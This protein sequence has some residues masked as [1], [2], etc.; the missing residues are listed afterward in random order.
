MRDTYDRQAGVFDAQRS[1]ALVEAGW[2]AR[3]ADAL[4]GSGR[5]LDLG[6]GTGRPIAGWLTR[7]G[8]RVTGI[9]IAPAMIEIAR[10]HCPEGDWRIADMR[11]LDLPE[12]FD[13]LVGWDSFFHLSPDAQR[14]VLPRLAGHLRPGGALMLTVGPRAGEVR[15]RVGDAPVY[16]ASLSPAEYAT[17][18]EAT[19]MRLAGFHAEDPDC[20]GRSVLLARKD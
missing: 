10:R 6:C 8:F 2:L 20:G 18:L 12:R 7:Q 17:A 4:P 1:Q 11:R 16:H 9:D 5:V 3:F 19:G 15:G 13:G 14:A